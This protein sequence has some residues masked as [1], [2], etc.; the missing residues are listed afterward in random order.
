MLGGVGMAYCQFVTFSFS[1]SSSSR[2]DLLSLCGLDPGPRSDAIV[3][4]VFT[5]S[6]TF[7]VPRIH[8]PCR[9]GSNASPRILSPPA[10]QINIVAEYLVLA[11]TTYASY[12]AVISHTSAEEIFC[13]GG[14]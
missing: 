5:W 14:Y 7:L 1:F 13:L 4:S 10:W 9:W 8:D 2:F 12:A 3:C 6:P 11:F